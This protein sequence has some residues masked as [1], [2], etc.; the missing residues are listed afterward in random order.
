MTLTFTIPGEPTGKARARVLKSGRAFTPKQTK[1]Y[2]KKVQE[3][4]LTQSPTA[5]RLNTGYFI[6]YHT[7]PVR[8]EIVA[9]MK[10]PASHYGT[11]RNAGKLKDTAPVWPLKKPDFDNIEKAVADA[12][13]GLAY[14]DDSQIVDSHCLKP[15][16]L[17]G[18]EPCV[19]VSIIFMEQETIREHAERG[20]SRCRQL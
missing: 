11:G 10:R 17:E 5:S 4:F 2:Q 14:K 20:K 12:L 8:L 18:F 19:Q 13:N 16:Q 1:E 3:A 15:Y 7:G 6:S 9:Y